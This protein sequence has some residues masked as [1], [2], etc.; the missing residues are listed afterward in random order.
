M[1]APVDLPQNLHI[2][3]VPTQR[4]PEP[5]QPESS[6]NSSQEFQDFFEKSQEKVQEKQEEQKKQKQRQDHSFPVG[7]QPEEN[8]DEYDD[9]HDLLDEKKTEINDLGKHID[10]KI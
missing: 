4:I 3:V 10:T 9:Q 6:S 1:T 5:K 2:H 7:I 8:P